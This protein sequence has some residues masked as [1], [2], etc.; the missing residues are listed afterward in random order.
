MS[1]PNSRL[2]V[3]LCAVALLGTACSSGEASPGAGGTPSATG[4]SGTPSSSSGTPTTG[5]EQTATGP[6]VVKVLPA[7][8]SDAVKP[9]QAVTV[10]VTSGSITQLTVKSPDADEPLKGAF[11]ADKTL[12]TG[13]PQLKPGADYKVTGTATG[14]D[15]KAVPI[16]S[17]FSVQSA[18][19]RLK[20]S[21]SP[22]AGMNVGVGMPIMIFWNHAVKD[23]AAVERRL[24]VTT[25]VPVEGS[26]HWNDDK[27][28]NWRPK[29]WWPAKTKVAVDIDTRGV[30]AGEGLWGWSNRH[31]EFTIGSSVISYVDVKHHTMTVKINGA[32]ARK[33]PIT[34]GKAG[35]TTR[36][37]IKLIME[38]YR[39]K[40]MDART[41][42]IK[43]G[44]PDY[45]DIHNVQ[46][47]HR[48]TSSGEF[49]HG[50]PWSTGSQGSENV[51]HGCVGMS[52]KNGAWY[53]AQTHIGD[54][55]IVT[56]TKRTIEPGNGWTDWDM[57]WDKYKAAS[58]LS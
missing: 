51:S 24:K 9:D 28:V 1:R 58:A 27:Q 15:G 41:V 7:A 33:V 46:Y 42:G 20:A 38:K 22:I 6:A 18:D 19:L 50:A 43:P 54:P 45:Y 3:A 56:G 16:S 35:F 10:S 14:T 31:I 40:R 32:T 48:V 21:M 17:S 36:S 30:K 57:S 4:T 47:A 39:V 8:K 34:A 53:F 55:V 37:G 23:K 2:V 49:V 12:W 44:D 5:G 26:W 11:N 25:S 29:T 13:L 52:L